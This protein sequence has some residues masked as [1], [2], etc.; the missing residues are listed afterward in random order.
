MEAELFAQRATLRCLARQHPEWT[1]AELATTLHRSR[2]WV[3]KWLARFKEVPPDDLEVLYARSR[4]RHIPPPSTPKAVVERILAI[5]DEPPEHLRRVPGPK[6]ILY[7]LPRDSAAQALGLPLPRSTRTIWK[8]LRQ[9]GRYS[10]GTAASP[11]AA[12]T[13]CAAG[14]GPTRLQRCDDGRSGTR[15][16][17][18]ARR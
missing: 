5:R 13:P 1:Q 6:A 9:H 3:V 2:S 17:A 4:A 14:G 12:A 16:E 8:I 7:Y 15:R 10:A 11:P 18:A